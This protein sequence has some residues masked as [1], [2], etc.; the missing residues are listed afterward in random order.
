MRAVRAIIHIDNFLGNFRAVRERVGPNRRICVPVK[1]DAYG[2]GAL[3]IA[4]AALEAGAYCL[5]VA[6]TGEGAELREGGLAAPILLLSQPLPGEIPEILRRRLTPLVSD[7]AFAEALNRAAE[8]AGTRLPVHLKIDT[9]MNRLGCSPEDAPA[10]AR[11]LSGCAA[12]DYE[13]TATHLSASDSA[14][15]GDAAYT[16]TQLERFRKALESIRAAGID[17]GIA[18]AAN[19]GGVILHPGSWLDMVRPGIILYGYKALEDSPPAAEAAGVNSGGTGRL[20]VKPVMELRADIVFIKKV[21]KGGC[22]SYGRIWTAPADT[23][24]ATLPVG[25]ADGLPRSAS[26]KWQV[27][28]GGKTYPLV[29]RICMDQCLVDLGPET[30]LR[31]WDELVVFGGEAPDAAVLAERIGTIPYEITC[32]INRRVPRVYRE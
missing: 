27:Y 4:K 16:R 25:Y 3:R 18:H 14:D 31:R 15:P 22:V 24:I 29:G 17:P 20:R 23:V 21:K 8:S 5:A 9:G 2:H 6:T 7:Q 30:D 32:N 1:A 26:G 10:L 13:G 12:L 28:A 19:S 11:F